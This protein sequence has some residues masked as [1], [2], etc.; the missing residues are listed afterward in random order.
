MAQPQ[1]LVL[2]L[3]VLQKLIKLILLEITN[4]F[5]FEIRKTKTLLK[6]SLELIIHINTTFI[7]C[8]PITF[9]FI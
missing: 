3:S 5:F 7:F 9:R 6:N 2:K 8:Y 1:S 4:T